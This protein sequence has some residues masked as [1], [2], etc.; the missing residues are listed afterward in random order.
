M[1][2]FASL[3]LI[4]DFLWPYKTFKS[5]VV[6]LLDVT[7]L[8]QF[9]GSW[10]SIDLLIVEWLGKVPGVSIERQKLYDTIRENVTLFSQVLQSR[11]DKVVFEKSHFLLTFKSYK[12]NHE[13][14]IKKS[15]LQLSIKYSNHQKPQT[16]S[17]NQY[18]VNLV[19][20]QYKKGII[21][22]SITAVYNIDYSRYIIEWFALV[23]MYFWVSFIGIKKNLFG[24]LVFWRRWWLLEINDILRGFGFIKDDFL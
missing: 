12:T 19:W 3:I 13:I 22:V 11:I 17:L 9:W 8:G 6:F 10:Y 21:L 20:N 15:H 4:T 24:W 14:R 7:F 2:R 1:R 23:W 5:V 16:R 18:K